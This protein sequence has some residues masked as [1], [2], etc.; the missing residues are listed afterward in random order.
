MKALK[1]ICITTILTLSLAA[2]VAAGEITT[3]GFTAPPPPP[4][5]E[6]NVTV[7]QS[8]LTEIVSDQ[9]PGVAPDVTQILWLLASIF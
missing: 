4:P 1:S 5:P 2:S 8:T 3:P 6:S 9:D 7:E